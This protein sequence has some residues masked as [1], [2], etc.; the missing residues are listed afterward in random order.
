MTDRRRVEAALQHYYSRTTHRLGVFGQK[1][2]ELVHVDCAIVAAV[3]RVKD[4]QEEEEGGDIVRCCHAACFAGVS[5]C[6]VWDRD[7]EQRDAK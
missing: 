2:L 6:L 7:L 4:L 1:A 3:D 5:T